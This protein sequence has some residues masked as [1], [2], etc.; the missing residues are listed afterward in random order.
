MN[1]INS[2]KFDTNDLRKIFFRCVKEVEKVE[3]PNKKYYRSNYYNLYFKNHSRHADWV[4]GR[5]SL[6]GSMMSIL[7]PT[8]WQ[9]EDMSV[10]KR[11]KVARTIIHE[12][13]HN[14]GY[15]NFDRHGYK[16]DTTK[17][18]NVDWVKD[19]PVG[20]K[21]EKPKAKVDI[22]EIRYNRAKANLEKA[23]TRF[24]RS[25]TLM[26]KWVKKVKYYELAISK[27]VQKETHAS[28]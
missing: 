10:E 19:Y 26:N 16:Y 17:T 7:I 20:L 3:K 11:V 4:G 1:T 23:R 9:N 22:Q 24:K 18:W 28:D 12:Y 15:M 21:T 6:S 2:T 14:L 8:S 25:K 27:R 13:Y 5:G